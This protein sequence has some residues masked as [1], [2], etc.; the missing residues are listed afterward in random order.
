M[1]EE[2][3]VKKY[4]KDEGVTFYIHFVNGYAIRQIEEY[5]NFTIKLS[6]SNPIYKGS[7]LCDQ[8]LS[9]LE[10]DINDY[11]SKEIFEEKWIK[12]ERV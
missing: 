8:L 2:I 4:W 12:C 6:E 10:L 1:I 7:F 9:N 5:Q 11:I 3:F